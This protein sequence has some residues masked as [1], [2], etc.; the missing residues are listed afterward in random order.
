[1]PT[2]IDF[3]YENLDNWLQRHFISNADFNIQLDDFFKRNKYPNYYKPSA[4]HINQAIEAM[5]KERNIY[6]KKDVNKRNGIVVCKGKSFEIIPKGSK[7]PSETTTQKSP[8]LLFKQQLK[9]I[10]LQFYG[11]ELRIYSVE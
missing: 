3:I 10:S 5:A 4:V 2:L 9:N 7:A 1:M 8:K 6:Y 11:D